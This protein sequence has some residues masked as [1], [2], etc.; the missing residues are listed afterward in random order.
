MRILIAALLSASFI[1]C[2]SAEVK[3]QRK[4]TPDAPVVTVDY[5]WY[6]PDGKDTTWISKF[7]SS[8][9][10]IYK[11]A[12]RW[13]R[14]EIFYTLKLQTGSITQVDNDTSSKLDHLR[15]NGNEVNP[16]DALYYVGQKAK[17]MTNNPSDILCLVTQE[18]LTIYKGGFDSYHPLCKGVVPLI[19]TYDSMNATAT[20]ESLGFLIR[21]T[22][23]ITNVYTWYY[24]TTKEEKK[25]RFDNCR[26]QRQ[27]KSKP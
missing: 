15:K 7:N 25:Q 26:F 1:F 24:N 20:G 13:L 12:R 27:S 10:E 5:L 18:P 21:D 14:K 9:D 16:F 17:E 8:L 3:K 19:L 23:N 6:E 11:S 2:T 22:L 4:T